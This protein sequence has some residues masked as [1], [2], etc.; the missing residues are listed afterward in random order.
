MKKGPGI[1]SE[2]FG[3]DAAAS[4]QFRL[5]RLELYNWGTFDGLFDVPVAAKGF[6]V[7][8]P[9]G[10]GKSSL[11]DA[12]AS[13]ITPQK[14]LDFN[15][16]ARE[17]ERRG[18]DRNLVTY[19]R[20]AWSQQT[21]ELGETAVQYLR[22]GTTWSAIAETYQ[23]GLG[24]TV[25]LALVLWLRGTSNATTDVRKQYL[26]FERPFALKELQFFASADF[27]V[28]KLKQTLSDAVV[29]EEFSAYRERFSR[30]LGIENELALKLLHKTQSAKNLGDLN[31]FLR[32]FMLDEPGTFELANQLVAEFVDLNEAHQSV[33]TARRQIETLVPAREEH[34]RLQGHL[35]S[36]D[37]LE[38]LLARLDT[39]REQ[40]RTV[41]LRAKLEELRIESEA[42]ESEFALAQEQQDREERLLRE[43]QERRLGAGGRRL[44]EWERQIREAESQKATRLK[45][46]EQIEKACQLLDRPVPDS[47]RTYAELAS[48]A[49]VRLEGSPEEKARIEA[50]KDKVKEELRNV[51]NLLRETRDEIEAMRRQSSNIPARMLSLRRS[52]AESV[53]V[54]EE[55]L[56]FAGELIEVRE[57]AAAWQGAIERVLHNLALS[58]LVDERLYPAVSNHV[59]ATHLDGR[60]LVYHRTTQR[61][62][63]PT[64]P[65]SPNSLLTKLKYAPGPMAEWLRDELRARFDYECAESM[66]AFR[67]ADQA[68]TREGQVKHRGER[69]E[70]DDRYR[71]DDRTQWVL[72]F[73]N[74]SKLD[75]FIGRE[76]DLEQQRVRLDRRLL[77]LNQDDSAHHVAM[78]AC[79]TLANMEWQE[80]D[81][82][83]L[84]TRIADLQRQIEQEKTDNPS[85]AALEVEITDQEKRYKGAVDKC[86]RARGATQDLSKKINT[87]KGVL[88]KERT[89]V[90]VPLTP[91]QQADLDERYTRT[92]RVVTVESLDGVTLDVHKRLSA[93]KEQETQAITDLRNLIER[94]FA[95]F[96]REW[97]AEGGGLDPTL[98]SAPDFF[99]KLK[100]LE[101]DNLPAFEDRF[102]RLLREQSDQNLTLL[103]SQLEQERK[104]ILERLEIVNDSLRSREFNYGTHLV[105]EHMD[106]PLEDV[107]NFKQGLRQAISFALADDADADEKRFEILQALV[108]RL[109]SQ[110]GKDHTW[111]DLVLD[112]RQHVEF[113]ARELDQDGVEIEVYRSGAG[114][115]GGQRQKLTSTCLAAALRYQLGGEDIGVPRYATVVLDE[116]FDKADAEFTT[117]AMRIFEAFGFQMIVATPLKSVMTLEPFIGG[118]CFVHI[119]DRK[120]SSVLMIEYDEEKKTLRLPGP[121]AQSSVSVTSGA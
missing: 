13:L 85:L 2:L 104:A 23:N 86:N 96:V 81:V 26:I 41:L 29:R 109:S 45:N 107:R 30:L 115:S 28:R 100:R 113:I 74:R 97:P 18:H 80:F 91:A 10:S 84:V 79:Q 21:G 54:H 101:I 52:I 59:N 76:A 40:K 58:L 95:D 66:S 48:A 116:A 46:R 16:A 24:Q 105:I 98:P 94:R 92:N 22:R 70:K 12:H 47:P 75:L 57:D 77:S 87:L 49:R 34:T 65:L 33:V 64:R 20:G 37:R 60:R 110:E 31:A 6:L 90:E 51:A 103:S 17:N 118:A 68:V 83:T 11:L 69:H 82:A 55:R 35:S 119:R 15:V 19:I 32:D 102:R 89:E 39:Y 7:I 67:N 63:V 44:E 99:A 3:A 121:D 73:Q 120:N 14:W 88:E 78:L 62:G 111:R 61:T 43:L 8:G 25:V 9:S 42:A 93:E 38:D 117:M 1:N 53:G 72:G 106:R 71:I 114:K 50:E 108:K 4:E 112:V 56:P 27:D 5:I 36:R